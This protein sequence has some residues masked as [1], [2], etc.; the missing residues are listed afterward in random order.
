MFFFWSF[1]AFRNTSNLV[2]T[3]R[4]SYE[5]KCKQ[6]EKSESEAEKMKFGNKA[7]DREKA[8]KAATQAR[9]NAMKADDDYK[10]SVVALEAA[11]KTWVG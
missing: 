9:A 6:A 3:N 10:A 2:F 1:G 8:S 5:A 11:R 7:R 4:S